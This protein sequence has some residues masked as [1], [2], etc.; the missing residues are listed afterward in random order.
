[1]YESCKPL[2]E[3]VRQDIGFL[4][5]VHAKAC[6]ERVSRREIEKLIPVESRLNENGARCQMNRTEEVPLRINVV[7]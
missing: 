1:M 6:G 5:S 7:E 4:V 3:R 2:A